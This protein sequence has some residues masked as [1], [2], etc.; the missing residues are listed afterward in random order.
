M[1][2]FL[3][4]LKQRTRKWD[5]CGLGIYNGI[6]SKSGFIIGFLIIK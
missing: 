4:G 2:S 1:I 3:V 5:K 6:F